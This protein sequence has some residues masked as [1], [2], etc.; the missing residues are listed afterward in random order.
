MEI[1][2]YLAKLEAIGKAVDE[3][4]RFQFDMDFVKTLGVDETI[5]QSIKDL[6]PIAKELL[7]DEEIAWGRLNCLRIE[8][9]QQAN[10]SFN[11]K[12][13][14]GA[15]YYVATLLN[16]ENQFL[17]YF[18]P[19]SKNHPA[20][21]KTDLWNNL[22]DSELISLDGCKIVN[23]HVLSNGRYFRLSYYKEAMVRY[24]KETK[25]KYKVFVR[26]D[27]YVVLD[28]EPPKILREAV[29]RPIDPK[30]INKLK[31]YP[32]QQTAGEYILQNPLNSL[33]P[34]SHM[35]AEEQ[36]AA[37]EYNIRHI[38]KLD[39]CV[40]RGNN[41]NL[42]MM[43]EELKD[44]AVCG[45]YFLGKCIHLDTDD[46]VGTA[47]E[48]ALLNHIDLA[49]NVYDEAAFKTR[50]KQSLSHGKVTDAIVRTHI[51]RVDKVPFTHL[52]QIAAD[53]LDS[54]IL[55]LEWMNDMF[56]GKNAGF[57]FLRV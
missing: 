33:L 10:I 15:I 9:I 36:L 26:I 16:S 6:M 50:Q 8:R 51:M 17:R 7:T 30:W 41:K 2:E 5:F 39:V 14:M 27:P 32:G 3:K 25:D 37:W 1:E 34:N 55:Y 28:N 47:Y 42:H 11:D 44:E 23:D 20:F 54:R 49:I 53:F 46:V 21:N 18:E 13:I 22:R 40:A 52:P 4:S 38:R 56:G 29:I 24:L 43:I 35:S 45:K 57:P 19:Y 12:I 31:I 48:D